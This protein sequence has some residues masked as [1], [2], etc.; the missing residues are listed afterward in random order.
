MHRALVILLF[1]EH[2]HIGHGAEGRVT[3]HDFA[4]VCALEKHHR[5]AMGLKRIQQVLYVQSP[6]Q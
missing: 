4:Q 1:H 3:V 6:A 2:V 5:D